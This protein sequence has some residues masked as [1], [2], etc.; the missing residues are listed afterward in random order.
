MKKR[1]FDFPEYLKHVLKPYKIGP[2]LRSRCAL[3]AKDKAVLGSR[4]SIL[5]AEAIAGLRRTHA[6]KWS[7]GG[8][9]LT[10]DEIAMVDGF[11]PALVV[12]VFSRKA[13][14]ERCFLDGDGNALLGVSVSSVPGGE[15]YWRQVFR[16]MVAVAPSMAP[17]AGADISIDHLVETMSRRAHDTR[18]D[19]HAKKRR[20]RHAKKASATDGSPA[21]AASASESAAPESAD[22]KPE[23][24]TPVGTGT[25]LR[26]IA[27]DLPSSLGPSLK[28]QFE[29]LCQP[30]P[31]AGAEVSLDALQCSL[32]EEFPHMAEAVRRVIADARTAAKFGLRGFW[33][34]PV[35]LVGPP[36]IGKTRF[37][38][39]LAALTGVAGGGVS[40][41][42]APHNPAIMGPAPGGGRAAP[43]YATSFMASN[44]CPNPLF[45]I[46]EIEKASPSR[47]NG[48]LWD[49]LLGMLEP[50]TA[51]SWYDECV[52][53][54]F[55]LRRVS[56]LLSANDLAPLPP[57]LVN[58]TTVCKI[59][60]PDA[61]RIPAIVESMV[62]EIAGEFGAAE[63]AAPVFGEETLER[64]VRLYQDGRS[65]RDIRTLVYDEIVN[66]GASGHVQ[67]MTRAR[68]G[69]VENR[70][71][72]C[73]SDQRC[74]GPA[75]G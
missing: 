32:L 22:T 70:P 11:L 18:Q 50:E 66:D 25:P 7:I 52:C 13:R 44:A 55:D 23:E 69:L 71:P 9:H 27:A 38:R 53:A 63:G 36:G 58:R 6:G 28:K 15:A 51:K 24:A 37:G 39:R 31:L 26:V 35:L 61:E 2:G 1:V 33:F 17:S 48:S 42:G 10:D 4:L 62:R 75:A 64:F 5:A 56:W 57:A 45:L 20:K 68:L 30:I 46:D 19:K 29:P 40:A 43:A 47:H 14:R 49:T 72:F 67:A 60:K 65:L 3:F 74:S 16:V 59:G 54:P 34:R 41:G 73:P 21:Q 8:E 12:P